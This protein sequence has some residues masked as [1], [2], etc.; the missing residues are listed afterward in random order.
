MRTVRKAGVT[1]TLGCLAGLAGCTHNHY[2]YGRAL[3]A[4]S[5]VVPCDPAVVSGPIVGSRPL[6]SAP[7]VAGTYCDIPPSGSDGVVVAARPAKSGAAVSRTPPPRVVVSDP[8][9]GTVR[10]G[11]RKRGDVVDPNTRISG[12][13]EDDDLLR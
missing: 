4:G 10:N 11:W 5:A 12:T 2:Y 8:T 3:P 9:Y 1:I 6:V 7:V 13:I